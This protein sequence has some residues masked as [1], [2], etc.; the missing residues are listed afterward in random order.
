[1]ATLHREFSDNK[2]IARISGF[3]KAAE[4]SFHHLAIDPEM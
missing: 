2:E 4:M 1:M 3:C